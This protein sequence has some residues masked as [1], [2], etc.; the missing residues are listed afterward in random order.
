MDT[1]SNRHFNAPDLI[2]HLSFLNFYDMH[3]YPINTRDEYELR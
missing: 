2:F 1:P 3:T